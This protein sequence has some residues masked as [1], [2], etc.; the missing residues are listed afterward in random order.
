MDTANNSNEIKNDFS[1]VFE[2]IEE[3]NKKNPSIAES[4]INC[5]DIKNDE[6]IRAFSDI[7]REISS[8]NNNN[9]VVFLTFS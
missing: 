6:A 5:E 4:G 7:C 8:D 3:Y 9:P 2:K 1:I